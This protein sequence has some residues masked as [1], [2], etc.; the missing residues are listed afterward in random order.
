MLDVNPYVRYP[1]LLVNMALCFL[2]SGAAVLGA[3]TIVESWNSN[4][5][6]DILKKHRLQGL[7]WPVLEVAITVVGTVLALASCCG[8]VGALREN[9]FLLKLYSWFL[10]LLVAG[11]ILVGMFV[12]LMPGTLWF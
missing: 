7:T 11:C 6:L 1:L 9:S 4:G 8:C 5:D 12:M 2:G 10:E 3:L